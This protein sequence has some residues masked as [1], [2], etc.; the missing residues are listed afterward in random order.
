MLC[1]EDKHY[2]KLSYH[3]QRCFLSTPA[4]LILLC[5]DRS[6]KEAQILLLAHLPNPRISKKSL[7]YDFYIKVLCRLVDT[8][9]HKTLCMHVRNPT[10]RD[11]FQHMALYRKAHGTSSCILSAHTCNC[12]VQHIYC[13]V[14][15]TFERSMNVNMKFSIIGRKAGKYCCIYF[16]IHGCKQAS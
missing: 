12:R 2:T 5:N 16:C 13:T 4:N 14:L 7:H 9:L 3:F 15:H 11:S 6:L 8:A 10:L 1:I